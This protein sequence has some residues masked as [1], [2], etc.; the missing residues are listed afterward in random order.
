MCGR[1]YMD[2][3]TSKEIRTIIKQLDAKLQGDRVKRGDISPTNTAPILIAKEAQVQPILST[4]GFPNFNGKGLIINARVET[5]FEK[6][7]FQE[8][9]MFRR[10]IIPANGF[11]EWNRNKEKN[12]FF[13]PDEDILYM[14]G[15]YNMFQEENHFVILTT[16]AISPIADI[17]DRMPFIL[18]KDQLD[19]WLFDSSQTQTLLK[20]IPG[21]LKRK[22]E[23]E[24]IEFDFM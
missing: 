23:Y 7:M 15:I 11:Y 17:H 5:A 13:P 4:W 14:A 1:Y 12:Y 21:I 20:Q 18:Q 16:N 10:C 2:D 22:V 3:E 6:K 9:L 8:N 19:S 24:Q